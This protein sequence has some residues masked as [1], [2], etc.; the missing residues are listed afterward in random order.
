MITIASSATTLL[1][2]GPISDPDHRLDKIPG[3]LRGSETLGVPPSH[4]DA[5]AGA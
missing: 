4:T 3:R 2:R 5:R 1:V